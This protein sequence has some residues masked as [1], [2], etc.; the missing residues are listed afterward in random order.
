MNASLRLPYALLPS[1]LLSTIVLFPGARAQAQGSAQYVSV[2]PGARSVGVK[3]PLRLSVFTKGTK[4][5]TLALSR[6]SREAYVDL[7]ISPWSREYARKM[8]ALKFTLP[9]KNDSSTFVKQYGV[10]DGANYFSLDPKLEAGYY[11]ISALTAD[12]TRAHSTLLISNLGLIAKQSDDQVLLFVVN[13]TSGVPVS[14]ATIE[15]SSSGSGKKILTTNKSGTAV[16]NLKNSGINPDRLLLVARKD[17][18]EAQLTSG[19]TPYLDTKYQVYIDTDRP[20]YKGGHEV[21]WYAVVKQETRGKLVAVERKSVS[22]QVLGADGKA[23]KKGTLKLDSF[24]KTGAAFQAPRNTGGFF[25]IRLRVGGENHQANFLIKDYVKPTM[26]VQVLPDEPAVIFGRNIK[27]RIKAKFL[28]GGVPSGGAVEYQVYRGLYRAPG[29]EVSSEE[30]LFELTPNAPTGQGELITTGKGVL[31]D[32]GEMEF[33]IP[34]KPEHKQSIFTIRAVVSAT[35]GSTT[36]DRAAGSGQVKVLAGA[37]T[38]AARRNSFIIAPDHADTIRVQLK[39]L[40]GAAVANQ[41][42]E[43]IIYKESWDKKSGYNHKLPKIEYEKI[44]TLSG[45][46]NSSGLLELSVKIKSNGRYRVV[47]RSTDSFGNPITQNLYYWVADASFVADAGAFS[48]IGLQSDKRF[49]RPGD[50]AQI[51]ISTSLP[52]AQVLVTAEGDGIFLR[53][54]IRMRGRTHLFALPLKDARYVPNLYFSAL[55]VREGRLHN[56]TLPVFLSPEERFIQTELEPDKKQYRPGDK[57][58]LRVK[59]KDAR[60]QGTR[61]SV[62]VGVVDEAIFLVQSRIAP[63]IEK[64]FYGRRPNRTRLS[65]SFPPIFTGG[66]SKDDAQQGDPERRGFKDTAYFRHNVETDRNGQA[67]ISFQ[68]PANLTTWRITAVSSD[69]GHLVGTRVDKFLSTK[70]LIARLSIP[71]FL[72]TGSRGE[73]IAIIQN[74]TDQDLEIKGNFRVKGLELIGKSAFT[75]TVKARGRTSFKVGVRASKEDADA[76]IQFFLSTKDGKFTDSLERRLPIF[77]TGLTHVL[78]TDGKLLGGR[79]A[80]SKR[81][82]SLSLAQ[83]PQAKRVLGQNAEL[84]QF[85]LVVYPN[86]LANLLG[87][88]EFLLEYPHGCVEQ[89]TSRFLPNIQV[90]NFLRK[91]KIKD[92]ALEKK[93]NAHVTAGIAN[94]LALQNTKRGGWGWWQSRNSYAVNHWMTAYALYGLVSARNAGFAVDAGRLKLGLEALRKTMYSVGP[95]RSYSEVDTKDYPKE[96]SFIVF[97]NYILTLAGQGDPSIADA[98]MVVREQATLESLGWAAQTLAYEQ[99]PSELA[100]LLRVIRARAKNYSFEEKVE[101][102]RPNTSDVYYTSI[103][104]GGLFQRGSQAE[105]EAFVR[106]LLAQ[107]SFDGKFRST[108]DTA[109]ALGTLLDYLSANR[110]LLDADL[111]LEFSLP[112]GK[113]KSLNIQG[114]EQRSAIRIPITMPAGSAVTAETLKA[115]VAFQGRGLA[116]AY[117]VARVFE[118]TKQFVP[119]DRGLSVSRVYVPEGQDPART[120]FSGT[121]DQGDGL[122]VIVTVKPHQNSGNYMLVSE[123]IPPGFVVESEFD[124]SYG[125]RHVVVT[126]SFVHFYVENYYGPSTLRYRLRSVNRGSFLV[127]P[128]RAELMYDDRIHGS[129]A[130]TVLK[131]E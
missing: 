123:P 20:I 121:I 49:Y 75:G 128:A 24:G 30:R 28:H 46:T 127:P 93:L 116:Q 7:S 124:Y 96:E 16:L 65:W 92:A 103:A 8:A 69:A 18:Q 34:T 113:A 120:K 85:E 74:L 61:A 76:R 107:R 21:N 48:E 129:S 105:N 104:L 41:L 44:D 39:D 111:K 50:T 106:R 19:R 122:D 42:V 67:T 94:L 88:L 4:K 77:E 70:E 62:S 109:A 130:A 53:R 57:V 72:N 54:L 83:D 3:A 23:F 100:D 68:L 13:L 22:Y 55:V 79:S 29:F 32:S 114:S 40:R 12:G 66:A 78:A 112:D 59:T 108:R 91:H 9:T 84:R 87:S 118:R 1:L 119:I 115:G 52:N 43:A 64:F 33:L 51:L 45:K 35:D 97:G 60:G 131:V 2:Y 6:L 36:T 89:T 117:L 15:A 99:R 38:M 95:G 47:L 73:A 101:Q 81:T 27:G 126:K 82:T 110:Q 98:V 11:L 10:A 17:H 125:R 58:T 25:V 80:S 63:S 71:R 26:Y 90:L 14:D 102:T 37:I 5:I 56:S 86:L 31:G